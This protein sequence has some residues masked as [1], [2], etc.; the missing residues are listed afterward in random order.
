MTLIYLHC[1]SLCQVVLIEQLNL[2]QPL[3]PLFL[4]S[5]KFHTDGIPPASSSYAFSNSANSFVQAPAGFLA[6]RLPES[7][8]ESQNASEA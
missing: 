8:F 3:K 5:L 7:T 4:A 1:S 2:H 6:I